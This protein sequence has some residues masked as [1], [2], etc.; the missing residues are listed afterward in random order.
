MTWFCSTKK[1]ALAAFALMSLLAL[2]GCASVVQDQKRALLDRKCQERVVKMLNAVSPVIAESNAPQKFCGCF[3]EKLD[4]AKLETDIDAVKD[5]GLN[6]ETLRFVTEYIPTNRGCAKE[7]GLWKNCFSLV[8]ALQ[9]SA[10]CYVA[11][12]NCSGSL[13]LPDQL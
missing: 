9:I 2:N 3:T 6:P 13:L 8:G 10:A 11:C 4:V 12:H 5:I 7:S 1:I